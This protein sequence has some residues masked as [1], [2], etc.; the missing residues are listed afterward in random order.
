MTLDPGE[1]RAPADQLA[2]GRGAMRPTP[3]QQDDPL[4]QAGLAR[5]IRTDDELRTGPE[6]RLQRGVSAEVEQAD[7]IEQGLPGPGAAGPA[8]GRR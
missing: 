3:G 2:V 6:G 8:S 4:E 1:V 7:G 5:G